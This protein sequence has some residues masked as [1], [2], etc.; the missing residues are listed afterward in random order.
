[1]SEQKPTDGVQNA[2]TR[3][4]TADGHVIPPNA[5]RGRRKGVKNKVP[6]TAKENMIAVFTRLGG[7]AAMARWARRNQS[8]FYKLYAKLIPL[9]LSGDPDGSPIQVEDISKMSDAQL[10]VLAG[11]IVASQQNKAPE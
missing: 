8:D 1:M 3:P 10:E 6:G 9:Q 4:R 7:T 11:R 5:G 2:D